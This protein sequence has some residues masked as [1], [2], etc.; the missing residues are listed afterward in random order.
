MEGIQLAGG[1]ITGATVAGATV[2]ADHYVA[3]VPVEIMRTLAGP[4][5]RAAEPRSTGSTGSSRA[6]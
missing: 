6:G 2:T 5:L 3:A 4:A 1:R